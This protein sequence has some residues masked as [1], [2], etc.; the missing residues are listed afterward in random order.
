MKRLTRRDDISHDAI[1]MAYRQ[2]PAGKTVSAR[3]IHDRCW[4]WRFAASLDFLARQSAIK[5]SA[6]RHAL[7]DAAYAA[8]DDKYTSMPSAHRRA[9]AP[10]EGQKSPRSAAGFADRRH[11]IIKRS[12]IREP[13]PAKHL[14]FVARCHISGTMANRDKKQHEIGS[15]IRRADEE[16]RG[17]AAPRQSA[18]V[19]APFHRSAPCQSWQSM[20][21]RRRRLILIAPP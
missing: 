15:A 16:C 10:G 8:R 7:A 6:G 21:S 18:K 3:F 1:A 12:M 5:S 9:Q 17:A 20:P 4:A 11:F 14:R 13:V 19:A 2:P